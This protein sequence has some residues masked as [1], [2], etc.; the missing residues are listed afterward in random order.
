MMMQ[1]YE[2]VQEVG[3]ILVKAIQRSKKRIVLVA[4][5]DFSHAGFNYRSTPPSGMRVDKYATE[6]ILSLDPQQLIETVERHTI[7][8]CGSGP[9]AAMLLVAK[10]LGG[11]TAELLKYG[12]SYDVHPDSSCVGYGAIAVS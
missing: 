4:S 7:T 10:K 5:S 2:A 1:D 3:A 6:D 11:T 12:T 9:V 8:M